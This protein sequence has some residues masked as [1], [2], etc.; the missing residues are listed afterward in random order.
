[1]AHHPVERHQRHPL[2][3][4]AAADVGMHARE[5]DLFDSGVVLPQ[6]DFE[7]RPR[8]VD[9]QRVTCLLHTVGPGA[10]GELE[11]MN[12]VIPDPRDAR[13]GKP[14][15]VHRVPYTHELDR[16]LSVEAVSRKRPEL[17]PEPPETAR[18]RGCDPL[19]DGGPC[20]AVGAVQIAY[21]RIQVLRGETGRVQDAGVVDE[22]GQGSRGERAATEAEHIDM[23]TLRIAANQLRVELSDVARQ[24]EAESPSKDSNQLE[25]LGTNAVVVDRDLLI[26]RG[27]A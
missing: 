6:K 20:L 23:V 18:Q 22:T 24:A 10:P 9:G 16:S 15:R 25:L 7:G 5:P 1:M 27:I 13:N 12:E 8:F 17:A 2:F 4:V 19:E 3:G 21:Y 11:P 26:I 14:D